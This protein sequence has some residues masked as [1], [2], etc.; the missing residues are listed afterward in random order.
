MKWQTGRRSA[1]V[2]DRRRVGRP[3]AVGGGIGTLVLALLV[4]L[5]GGDPGVVM[6]D[7]GAPAGQEGTGGSGPVVD[8]QQDQLADFV[9]VVLAD[10]EDTWPA[11]L[12]PYGVQYEEPRLVLFSGAVESACGFQQSAV[13]PFYCPPDHR[14]YLDLDFFDQLQRRFGAPGDFAQA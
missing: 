7:R 13:G 4:Y 1:N 14:V 11:L 9:S 2:E 3:L 10:T 12:R 8:A 5:L 6:Q